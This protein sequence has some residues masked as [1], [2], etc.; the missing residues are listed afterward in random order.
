MCST[1]ISQLW[2]EEINFP[3]APAVGLYWQD[4]D[5]EDFAFRRCEA[6]CPRGDEVSCRI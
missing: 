1:G 2:L 5:Q 4:I 3:S 6:S